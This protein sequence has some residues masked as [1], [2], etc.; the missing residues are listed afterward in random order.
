MREFI[1]PETGPKRKLF[2]AA[3]QLLAE[4]G[5]DAVSVRDVTRLTGAN[6]AA[7]NYHFG[8]RDGLLALVMMRHL[9]P[10][11]E[12]RL[13]RL[14]ALERKW[15]GKSVPLEEIVDA[16]VRPLLTQVRK[17]E[18]S[19][20]LHYRLLGR[21]L[22]QGM[23]D[24]PDGVRDL[25]VRVSDRFKRTL[26]K[27]LPKL[28][29]DDLAWRMHFMSGGVVHFLIHSEKGALPGLP[30]TGMEAVIG[31]FIRFAVA[32]LREGMEIEEAALKNGPQAMFQF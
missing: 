32:G 10:L 25:V 24:L 22:A 19:D 30:A 20:L 8:S 7:V 11:S 21:I 31:K 28:G 16:F 5:F 26:A 4:H 17:S 9:V 1:L 6:I 14:D 2:D 12:E 15:A 29:A 23:E 13:A 18:L 3:T 27:A